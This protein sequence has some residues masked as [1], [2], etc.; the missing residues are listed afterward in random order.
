MAMRSQ[1]C[2]VESEHVSTLFAWQLQVGLPFVLSFTLMCLCYWVSKSPLGL[3]VYRCGS[4]STHRMKS[5]TE[6]IES[7]EFS[8]PADFWGTWKLIEIGWIRKIVG[9]WIETAGKEKGPNLSRR[10]WREWYS[11]VIWIVDPA[12]LD[13]VPSYCTTEIQMIHEIDWNCL[14]THRQ[15]L[16]GF[17][18]IPTLHVYSFLVNMNISWR[19]E[20]RWSDVGLV[21]LVYCWYLT[22]G[23]SL[24]LFAGAC[25]KI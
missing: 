2:G 24:D 19:P 6:H 22:T 1:A 14:V 5:K 7:S 4:P 11:E 23:L 3:D 16:C 13:I 9:R 21:E 17:M 18:L 15:C 10:T 25:V 12:S 20:R 8:G